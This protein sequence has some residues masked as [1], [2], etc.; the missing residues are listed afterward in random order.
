MKYITYLMEQLTKFMIYHQRAFVGIRRWS[1][2]EGTSSNVLVQS[3]FT[4]V[5]D[6]MNHSVKGLDN[7][8]LNSYIQAADEILPIIQCW[9]QVYPGIT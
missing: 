3:N 9:A 7:N 2:Y 4:L 5:G 8:A 6:K 1:G